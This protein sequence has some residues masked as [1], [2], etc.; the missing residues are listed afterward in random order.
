MSC[1][2]LCTFFLNIIFLADLCLCG[3]KAEFIQGLL[4]ADKKHLA[5]KFNFINRLTNDVLSLSNSTIFVLVDLIYLI[6]HEI[7]DTTEANTSAPYLVNVKS[8]KENPQKLTQLRPR[9]YPRYLV[10]KKGRH[11]KTPSKTST[12]TAK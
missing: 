11:K 2:A 12:A 5:Q 7:K 6:E 8:R 4:K 9:S 10:G 1:F 3:Y